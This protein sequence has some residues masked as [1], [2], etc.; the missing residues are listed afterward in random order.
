[1]SGLITA[2]LAD[3][4]PA[5]RGYPRPVPPRAASADSIRGVLAACD[6]E[7]AGGRRDYAIL[8]VMAR[9]ALRGGEVAGLE[10]SDID[11]RAAEVTIRG[12]GNRTDVLPLPADV[13]DAIADYLLRARP[14]TTS[15][16][17]FVTMMAP[18]AGLAVSSVTVLTGRSYT[19][20]GVGRFGPHGMRHAAACELLAGGASMEEIGQLLRHAH[21]R[22]TAIY[23]KVDLARLA[24]LALPCP[25]GAAR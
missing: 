7:S 25:Q 5:G 13:G 18:F 10:L 8:L 3:A 22:T 15:R 20:A 19:R 17:L 11:W 21:E 14:A 12:K 16:S 1:M 4:V 24:A 9:L 6:R 2:P 23:A